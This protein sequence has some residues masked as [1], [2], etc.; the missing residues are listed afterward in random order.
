[1]VNDRNITGPSAGNSDMKKSNNAAI[2]AETSN[3]AVSEEVH[4]MPHLGQE[5][6]A[7]A[8]G[9]SEVAGTLTA[10]RGTGFRSNGTP[11]EGVAITPKGPRRFTPRE[12]ERLQGFPD[13]YTAITY[14]NKPACDSP[15]YKAL[16][17]SIVV[18]ILHCLGKRIAKAFTTHVPARKETM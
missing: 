5:T 7:D 9:S 13:D 4:N 11:I 8:V 18:P 12:C 16:G 10:S 6:G 2:A 3:R 17:N 1:M 15:R 14:R